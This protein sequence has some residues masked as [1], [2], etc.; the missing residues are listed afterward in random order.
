MSDNWIAL[1]PE[2]LHCVPDRDRRIRARDRFAEIA[3]DADEI[4]SK[5]SDD[6]SFRG[7]ASRVPGTILITT[8]WIRDCRRVQ[9]WI[10]RQA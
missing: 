9:V 8:S 4:E 2:D 10:A 7:I 5:V 1:I 6:S 3:P